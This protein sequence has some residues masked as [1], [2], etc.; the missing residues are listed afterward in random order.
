LADDQVTLFF[1][2]ASDLLDLI[3]TLRQNLKLRLKNDTELGLKLVTPIA[4]FK[5]ITNSKPA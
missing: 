1:V 3:G 2:T 4:V 5:R